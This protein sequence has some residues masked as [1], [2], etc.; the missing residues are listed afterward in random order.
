MRDFHTLPVVDVRRETGDAV[1]V[2]LGVPEELRS[3]YEFLPGQ[4][5]TFRKKIDGEEL[6]RSYSI[7]SE[8]AGEASTLRVAI[9]R[10]RFGVFSG[11][12]N[13]QLASGMELEVMPP[14]GHFTIKVEPQ[15]SRHYL[16][17][18]SGS[19]ITPLMSILQ[20]VLY[21]EP[22]SQF[23]LV[24]GNR[25][26]GSIMFRED[27]NDLKDRFPSRLSVIHL[28]TRETQDIDLF[29]GRIDGAKCAALFAGWIDAS[30]IDA[31]FVCGP[32]QMMHS[33]V[34][35]LQDVGL[36][37]E[38]IRFELFTT[39]ETLERK[40]RGEERVAAAGLSGTAHHLSGQVSEA[41]AVLDGRRFEF[42][43]DR[44]NETVLDA[45]LGS[46]VDL[47]Y[48]CKAGVCSTC[49]AKLVEGK[50][51]MDCHYGLE[52]GE[53]AAG[54]VLTCQSHPLTERV[55]VDFDQ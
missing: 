24:Y 35:A 51:R 25:T 36:T 16:G 15:A 17:I 9:K 40:A 26:T 6:R 2:T 33:T 34:S 22:N 31:A 3:V 39:Q 49:R 13:E 29:N 21:S 53:V 48:S 14:L 42:S 37:A 46:G 23:T 47:P 19:G 32:E 1:V 5:L 41:V 54:F 4:H 27:L 18:A 8:K 20:S 45:G 43:V 30:S 7:C 12:A 55:V 52:D 38:Q 11:W 50:V 10:A 28:L 44:E